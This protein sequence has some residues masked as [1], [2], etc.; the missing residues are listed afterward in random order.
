VEKPWFVV[1]GA[2]FIGTNLAKRRAC[3]VFDLRDGL[4]ACE[5]LKLVAHMRGHDTVV[6]LAAN[7]DIAAG[8]DNPQL[9][10]AGIDIT[11]NVAEAA[12]RSGV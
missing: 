5:Y 10:L 12:R 6:H 9:D 1:G 8:A 2:G 4:D 7:A 11:R 3:T